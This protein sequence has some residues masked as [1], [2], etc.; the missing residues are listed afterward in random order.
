MAKQGMD[1]HTSTFD[2]MVVYEVA[3]NGFIDEH[4]REIRRVYK[5]RRDLMLA[6]LEQHFPPE[7]R[8]TRPQ[9]G[10][11]LWVTLP[12]SIDTAE[13]L[14]RAIDN[15]VAYVPG[16]AFYPGSKVSSSFRFNFSNARPEQIEDGMRRL[17]EVVA[18]RIR[19]AAGCR[20]CL[21]T[22]NNDWWKAGRA[23]RRLY[24][25]GSPILGDHMETSI[26][27]LL[28]SAVRGSS[29]RVRCWPT[30]RWI[31]TNT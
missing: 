10:L 23:Q 28:D 20:A 5:E 4:V 1:L 31:R 14:P 18:Q 21:M 15:K 22:I 13:L 25:H 7:A 9:G 24:V 12:S 11:F 6:M 3:R 19:R 16:T 29:S 17:G 2:Q 26:Q 30:P 8:W 27:S